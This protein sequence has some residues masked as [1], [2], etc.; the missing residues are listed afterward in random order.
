[1]TLLKWSGLRNWAADQ[2]AAI[3]HQQGIVARYTLD[4]QVIPLALELTNVRVDSVDG[5]D[6]LLFANRV[7]VR[8]RLFSLLSGKLTI[9]HIDIDRGG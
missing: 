7:T 4:V 8:P 3:L 6:P 2:T 9:D 5:G 1:M